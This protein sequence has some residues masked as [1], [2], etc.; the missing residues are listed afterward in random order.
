MAWTTAE[1]A[2]LNQAIAKGVTQVRYA[3]RTV[4]YRSLDDMLRIRT[5]M[6]DELGLSTTSRS[7]MKTLGYSKG[8][9]G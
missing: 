4:E 7:V 5:L 3:D 6:T 1:L 2:A 9:Q 8:I